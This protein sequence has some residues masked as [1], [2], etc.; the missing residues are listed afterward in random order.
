MVR[1][2][3]DRMGHGDDGFPVSPVTR[4]PTVAGAQGT[5][6]L[7]DGGPGPFGERRS[8]PAISLARLARLAFPGALVVPGAEPRPAGPVAVTGERRHVHAGLGDGEYRCAAHSHG[9]GVKA[10]DH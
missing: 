10:R 6:L 1:D 7:A 4:D 8:Q 9:A 5:V 2:A 3:E